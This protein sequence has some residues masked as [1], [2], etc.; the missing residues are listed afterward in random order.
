MRDTAIQ[1]LIILQYVNS[2][3]VQDITRELNRYNGSIVIDYK[4]PGTSV[5]LNSM[6]SRID[7]LNVDRSERSSNLQGSAGRTQ[8]LTNSESN[9]TVLMNQLK[10]EQN[11]ENFKVECWNQLFILKNK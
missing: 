6:I 7:R 3:N 8:Y 4:S 11:V 9:T 2:L 10:I 1:A 5:F